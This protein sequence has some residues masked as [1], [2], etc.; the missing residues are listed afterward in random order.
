MNGRAASGKGAVL[1]PQ[2]DARL[3]NGRAKAA[4]ISA[5]FL[6]S[7]RAGDFRP[8]LKEIAAAA[9]VPASTVK[10]HFERV[11]AIGELVASINPDALVRAVGLRSLRTE[12][13]TRDDLRALAHALA[14]GRRAEWLK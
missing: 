13:F 8:S 6:Q 14:T 3:A 11:S 4:Q 10:F 2:H 1:E 9:Q 7:V 5:A 12:A